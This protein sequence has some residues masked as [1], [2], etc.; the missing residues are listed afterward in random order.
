MIDPRVTKLARVLVQYSLELKEGDLFLIQ[1]E[2]A[3]APLVRELYR[4][5]LLAGAYPLLRISVDGIEELFY[6]HASDAQLR[7]I[8]DLLR[9]EIEQISASLY[10]MGG[11]NTKNLSRSDPQKVALRR[12]SS[13]PL[14]ERFLERTA[15]G[16]LR[17]GVTLFPT[18]SSAQDAE[19]SLADY[20]DFV[21]GAG[22]LD[23]DDPVAA[24]KLVRDEQQRIA[25]FLGSKKVI[26]LVAPDTDL[27]YHT[28][29][30]SWINAAGEKNFPDGE[31][32]SSPDETKTEG[33]IRY[34]FPAVYA[35]REVVDVRLV[36]EQGKV[37]RATAA[38]GEDLLHSLLD[39][40]EGARRLGEAAFGTNYDIQQ[41]S[42]NTLFDEKIGG[43]I[44]L[45]LGASFPEIGGQNHS[46]LH[47][48]MV[49]DMREGGA[50]YADDQL[51]Y[52]DGKFLI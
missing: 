46:A 7:H 29:G 30:R 38:K 41:F 40:D 35:G 31:V 10:I 19:M 23:A 37:V 33:Q 52:K 26:R 5:A 39:M 15:A 25:D 8:P 48:D 13:Q 14:N 34:T 16:E 18:Q 28:A 42:R 47:W 43:T 3:C 27:T 17:W 4:E 49:C 50:A 22:K 12:Q 45:A 20:E 36:F 21:Y 24:W 32:F 2:A 9:Q 44:H 1:A 51:F 6:K 11:E